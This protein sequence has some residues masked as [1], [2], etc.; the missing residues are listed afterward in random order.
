MCDHI[1]DPDRQT[2]VPLLQCPSLTCCY[3][4]A[5]RHPCVFFGFWGGVLACPHFELSACLSKRIPPVRGPPVFPQRCQV[6]CGPRHRHRPSS[7]CARSQRPV[8]I[9]VFLLCCLHRCTRGCN[10][11]GAATTSIFVNIAACAILLTTV[12]GHTAA[13]RGATPWRNRTTIVTRA[14][15]LLA[16]C[17]TIVFSIWLSIFTGD[18]PCP[19]KNSET[20]ETTSGQVCMGTAGTCGAF[21]GGDRLANSTLVNTPDSFNVEDF[22]IIGD[23]IWLYIACSV[24][25]AGTAL[26]LVYE[27]SVGSWC[28]RCS[29]RQRKMRLDALA[30]KPGDQC[31]ATLNFSDEKGRITYGDVGI[32]NGHNMYTLPGSSFS[33]RRGA[34]A[35]TGTAM[36]RINCTFPAYNGAVNLR[37]VAGVMPVGDGVQIRPVSD[38][39]R[40]RPVAGHNGATHGDQLDST[41]VAIEIAPHPMNPKTPS[42]TVRATPP[43]PAA[44]ALHTL[45]RAYYSK[46]APGAKTDPALGKMAETI[47]WKGS[48]DASDAKFKAKYGISLTEFRAA[49]Q[50]DIRSGGTGNNAFDDTMDGFDI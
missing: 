19:L 37:P 46:F 28:L 24:L 27:N 18:P 5:H 7:L 43:S 36:E 9:Y 50:I 40:I 39:V 8:L 6:L 38:G 29:G 45:L 44:Q 32:V 26:L 30:L 33:S 41:Q 42:A 1:Q 23:G 48:M 11:Q 20:T 17:Y 3:M 16:G 4:R 10:A 49:Q 15:W 31:V 2:I 34:V 25:C 47:V 14:T 13:S 21:S 35:T 22:F 12:A